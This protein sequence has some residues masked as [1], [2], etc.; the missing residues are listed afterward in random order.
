[1]KSTCDEIK[2]FLIDSLNLDFGFI[3]LTE[4]IEQWPYLSWTQFEEVLSCQEIDL[5]K[6]LNRIWKEFFYIEKEKFLL[7]ETLQDKTPFI[8]YN[9]LVSDLNYN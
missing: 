6:S 2:Q 5:S 1:M 4:D 7:M 3:V 9:R 8:D